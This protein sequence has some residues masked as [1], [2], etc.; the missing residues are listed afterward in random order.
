MMFAIIDVCCLLEEELPG[1]F[2]RNARL[3]DSGDSGPEG[4]DQKHFSKLLKMRFIKKLH[5]KITHKKKITKKITKKNH[6]RRALMCKASEG[7]MRDS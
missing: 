2:R 5:K 3:R 4:E 7:F 6:K 1:G